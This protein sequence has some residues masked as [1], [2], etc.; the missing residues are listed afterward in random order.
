MEI[1]DFVDNIEDENELE[2]RIMQDAEREFEEQAREVESKRLNKI[3]SKLRAANSKLNKFLDRGKPVDDIL[4]E[5]EFLSQQEKEIKERLDNRTEI[6]TETERDRLI[7]TGK[8]NPF[9]KEED[10]QLGKEYNSVELYVGDSDEEEVLM[11]DGDESYYQRRVMGWV[12]KRRRKRF[13]GMNGES[14]LEISEDY[15]TSIE[16]E[17]TTPSGISPDEIIEEYKI[18]GDIAAHLFDYQKACVRWLW[19]LHKQKVGGVLGDEMGL[20]KTVQIVAFL[21]GL[22]YS[23]LLDGPILIV[24]PATVLKQW[25]QE[26]H[27]WWPPYRVAILHSSGSGVN[28]G[29]MFEFESETDDSE[30]E[31]QPKRRKYSKSSIKSKGIDSLLSKIVKKGHVLV[32]TYSSMT[33]YEDLLLKVKWAYCILDEGHKI[34]IIL[35]GTPIQNNLTE[36][37]SLYD[38]VYPGR[39]GTLPVF[40]SEFAVPINIG[41]YA[42]AT[43]VQVQTA[44]KC[45]C[46]LRDFI[47]PYMLRRM[48]V[49]VAQQLPKKSEQILFCKLTPIQKQK[50]LKYIHSEEVARILDGKQHVLS[51]IDILRKICNHPDLIEN[52]DDTTDY[53]AIEKS[54]KMIVVE[55]LLK[56]WH[57]YKNRVLLFCQTRQMLDIVEQFIQQKTSYKYLRMDGTT[58]IK[59][60][61]TLIDS[62]N[63]N[64]EIFLF[65]LTTRVGGLGINLTGADRCII[66]DPDWNPSVDLQEKI[67]QRQIFKQFLTNKILKDPRQRRFFKRNDLH[68]LFTYEDSA[69]G[70]TETE[71]LFESMKVAVK[72]KERIANVDKVHEFEPNN[73]ENDS[74]SADKG[75]L[76]ALFAKSGV[77]SALEHEAILKPTIEYTIMEDEARKVSEEAVRKLKIS[78]RELKENEIGQPTWTGKFGFAGRRFGAT[79]SKTDMGER[80]SAKII[81]NLKNRSAKKGGNTSKELLLAEEIYEYLSKFT[82]LVPSSQ[83]LD[84]FKQKFAKD[85]MVLLRGLLKGMATLERNGHEKGWKLK[86]DTQE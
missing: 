21:A 24:C 68:N 25:V 4:Q 46:I 75:I 74:P 48:K 6:V 27:K 36:L 59:T 2:N 19:E 39:L 53:G 17:F 62:F 78:R 81:T 65:L 30:N 84:H 40:Q 14:A 60:R 50:Y 63:Q 35:S 72:P 69:E 23:S 18:P 9:T 44:Y 79:D 73:L 5:I 64:T 12:V 57:L 29:G 76:E 71:N 85:E 61:S 47:S 54:G 1:S 55:N 8:I 16:D 66:Y 31:R 34:R 42:N 7:R 52:S 58:P 41:G 49:D 33:I 11:D 20:G 26:F 38:F 51:G 82:G 45:A 70:T 83:I 37:W 10:I 32:T 15:T 67:Y 77:H 3:Q 56:M 28:E 43:N 86:V 13:L 22:G 80:S